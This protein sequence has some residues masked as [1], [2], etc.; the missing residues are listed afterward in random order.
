[1]QGKFPI[2]VY[3]KNRLPDRRAIYET[4]ALPL[5]YTGPAM[6]ANGV[7]AAN[8]LAYGRACRP[9]NRSKNRSKEA[10]QLVEAAGAVVG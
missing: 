6:A 8:I 10:E 2:E 1:M 7:A 4:A 9:P 3:E 5:S